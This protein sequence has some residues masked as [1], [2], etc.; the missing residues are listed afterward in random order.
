MPHLL[1]QHGLGSTVFD[2]LPVGQWLNLREDSHGLYGVGKLHLGTRRGR[3][4]RS[5]MKAT[6]RPLISGLSV[7]YQARAYRIHSSREAGRRTLKDIRLFEVSLVLDPSNDLARVANS[8][9][10]PSIRDIEREFRER[11]YSASQSKRM[12][13]YAVDDELS[14]ALKNLR[15]SI[16]A[17]CH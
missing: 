11:G 8:K 10:G 7:G 2:S 12:A 4:V 13:R 14:C 6:P 17:A 5:M 3:E 9:A 1:L 16:R 15:D